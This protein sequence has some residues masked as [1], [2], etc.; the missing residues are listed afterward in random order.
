MTYSPYPLSNLLLKLR[1]EKTVAYR[2]VCNISSINDF[3]L[4]DSLTSDERRGLINLIRIKNVL[5]SDN[6]ARRTSEEIE[7]RRQNTKLRDFAESELFKSNAYTTGAFVN[8]VLKSE[9]YI[10]LLQG[11]FAPLTPK[12]WNMADINVVEHLERVLKENNNMYTVNSKIKLD[13]MRDILRRLIYVKRYI[14]NSL[15]H[16]R[17]DNCLADEFDEYF[18]SIGYNVSE[19]L[20]VKEIES[21]IRDAI[22]QIQSLTN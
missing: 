5:F 6:N 10:S 14:R 17:E 22:N 21:V 2:E 12:V 8:E 20:S 7:N 1:K 4:K 13:D 19:E 16:A 11:E 18:S 3:S 15:N 9:E